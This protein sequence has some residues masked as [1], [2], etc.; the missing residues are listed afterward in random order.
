[1]GKK[2][3]RSLGRDHTEVRR[4]IQQDP[5]VGGLGWGAGQAWAESVLME[6]F[7]A[8][9]GAVLSTKG[10]DLSVLGARKH[11]NQFN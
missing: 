8:P 3:R 7:G 2:T 4:T 5:G 6:V 11:R 9:Q 1:M 10:T